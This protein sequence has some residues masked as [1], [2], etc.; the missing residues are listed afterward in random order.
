MSTRVGGM[1]LLEPKSSLEEKVLLSF[2][3]SEF[4]TEAN[5]GLQQGGNARFQNLSHPEDTGKDAI[6]FDITDDPLDI[7]ADCLFGGD[8]VAMCVGGE[9]VDN[10]DSL[11][12]RLLRLQNFFAKAL[13]NNKVLKIILNVNFERE[14]EF[15]L[16]TIKVDEFQD[17]MIRLYEENSNWT[18]SLKIIIH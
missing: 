2:I 18:P 4:A 8:G 16:V 11:A 12:Y 5:I 14:E 6:T 9:R 13:S 3:L 17:E 10:G 7:N 15:N 1:F